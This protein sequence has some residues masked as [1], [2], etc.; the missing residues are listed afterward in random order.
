MHVSALAEPTPKAALHTQ[1]SSKHAVNIP[2]TQSLHGEPGL[3]LQVK[4]PSHR[5]PGPLP[6]TLGERGLPGA[7]M[8]MN[9]TLAGMPY[10]KSSQTIA[11]VRTSARACNAAVS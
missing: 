5:C 1:A 7:G 11:A 4:M 10:S 3:G 6:S 9:N 2:E 8:N